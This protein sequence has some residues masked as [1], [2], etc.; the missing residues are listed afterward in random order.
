MKTDT[1]PDIG[2]DIFA[3]SPS[4]VNLVALDEAKRQAISLWT[5]SEIDSN[6]IDVDQHL[7]PMSENQDGAMYCGRNLIKRQEPLG[8]WLEENLYHHMNQMTKQ[9]FL[10][11]SKKEEGTVSGSFQFDTQSGRVSLDG[12]QIGNEYLYML[13]DLLDTDITSAEILWTLYDMENQRKSIG[14]KVATLNSDWWPDIP[15]RAM[16]VA[17][18]YSRPYIGPLTM[19]MPKQAPIRDSAI[20]EAITRAKIEWNA[21]Q[22]AMKYAPTAPVPPTLRRQKASEKPRVRFVDEEYSY[23]DNNFFRPSIYP[24][25][26]MEKPAFLRMGRDCDENLP[27]VPI[28]QQNKILSKY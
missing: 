25:E 15:G 26:Q 23:D 28:E 10:F 21:V 9:Y 5:E 1:L 8:I 14:D 16:M 20:A 24:S 19:M 2:I 17:L 4:P 11:I 18:D 7:Q 27:S 6:F 12:Y 3:D 13:E 22:S